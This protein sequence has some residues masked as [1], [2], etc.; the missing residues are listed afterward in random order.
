MEDGE[1]F[2]KSYLIAISSGIFFLFPQNFGESSQSSFFCFLFIFSQLSHF[3]TCCVFTFRSQ[4]LSFAESG[5]VLAR[6]QRRLNL[7]QRRMRRKAERDARWKAL[8]SQRRK[9]IRDSENGVKDKSAAE[10]QEEIDD[11]R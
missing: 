9:N 8:M 4:T 5:R 1:S 10:R 6:E 3:N 11:R 7:T 2:R